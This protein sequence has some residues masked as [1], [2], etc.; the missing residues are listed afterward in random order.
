MLDIKIKTFLILIFV[1]VLSGCS[2]EIDVRNISD[3]EKTVV[4]ICHSKPDTKT[5]L[6]TGFIV[7]S[8]GIVV[9][10]DHVITDK[11]GRIFNRLFALRPNYPEVEPFQLSVVKRFRKGSKGRDI[12]ILK[13]VSDCSRLNLSY[14]PVGEKPAIGDP[15]LIVGFPLVFN[16]VY[17]WPLFRSGIV[18]STRYNV[19]NSSILLLDLPPVNGYSGS[20]VISLK[21]LK[22]VG[23]Y[24]G[25]SKDR[26]KTN[27]SIAT[28]LE[29][30]DIPS[31]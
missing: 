3:F 1:L 28:I 21:T 15:V 31:L 13:I 2:Q 22:V 8:K 26:P 23:I 30:C 11:E 16:K 4:A 27:F 24:K 14:M 17:S 10:A 12:S 6:G 5:I 7:A 18:A 20:P 25:H 19:D 29:K 9:T